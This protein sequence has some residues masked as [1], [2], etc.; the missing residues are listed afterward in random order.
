M[1]VSLVVFVV[2]VALSI[3]A[4]VI[5][6]PLAAITGNVGPLYKVTCMIVSAGYRVAGIRIQVEGRELVPAGRA[7]IFMANHVSNLDPPALISHIP[8]RTSAF[9]KRSVFKLPIFGYCLKLGE[10]IPVDRT[11]S[12]SGA[13]QSVAEAARLLAK[14][15]HITTFVEGTRSRDGRMQP[16]KKGPFYLA[17][18]TGAPCIPVSIYGTETM[19]AKGSFAIKPGTAHIIFHAPLYPRDYASREELSAAVRT[20]IASSLPEWMRN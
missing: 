5:F 19:M 20:V 7:C 11:G 13:Q 3:P 16:F 18:Q 12:A 8:G 4:A 9:T 1:I 17:M 2:I 14:G 6:I 10:F 15:I